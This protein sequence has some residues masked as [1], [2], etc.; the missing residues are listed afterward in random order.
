MNKLSKALLAAAGIGGGATAFG[1]ARLLGDMVVEGIRSAPVAPDEPDAGLVPPAAAPLRS[2]VHTADGAELNVLTYPADDPAD[3]SDV[4]VFIHG[5]TCN[6]AYWNPQ[7]NHL[8]GKRTI[9]AY[10]QRGHGESRLGRARPTPERLGADLEA[11][12][13]AAV[14][15]GR[16][17][18]LV[19][20]SMGGIT[21]QAWA[22]QHADEVN[23][24][25]SAVILESTAATDILGRHGLFNP[26]RPA[27]TKPFERLTGV[28][29]TSTPLPLPQSEIGARVTRAISMTPT[30]RGAH[31]VFV[32]EMVRSCSPIVRALCGNGMNGFD[33]RTGTG[34]LTVPTTVI[35][36]TLDRL[37]PPVHSD[38]MA[39]ILHGVG[40]L[41]RHVVLDD[42][43]HMLSIEASAEFNAV[44]DDVLEHAASGGGKAVAQPA[45]TK[46]AK[47]APAKTA[48][49]KAPAK[50]APAKKAP[51][52][53]A[54]AKTAPKKTAADKTAAKESAAKPAEP[55]PTSD[56]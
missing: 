11:V 41:Y 28:L 20:H 56:S 25:I 6:T 16:K 37:L 42:I 34:A 9:V 39:G 10:D 38:E 52:K 47:K 5:W 36:G 50:K 19:G 40:S 14:P 3:T 13:A 17:A 12:L 30:A 29:F 1:V 23:E 27:Y 24:R 35:N 22:D 15:V 44:L 55:K 32:D 51:A 54:P 45:A 43:G 4:V 31:V 2:H 7:V 8:L 48:A 46:A 18:V 53:K 49:K 21:I 33:V 26:D